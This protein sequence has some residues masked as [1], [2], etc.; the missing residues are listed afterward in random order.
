MDVA[1]TAVGRAIIAAQTLETAL[2]PI[3]ELHRVHSEPDRL[4]RTGGYLSAGAFKVPVSSMVKLLAERGSI[5]PNLENRLSAYVE[6]RH[7]LVHRWI[8]V[9]GIPE[10]KADFIALAKHALRVAQ[11]AHDL[12]QIFVRYVL[13]YAEPEWA[14]ANLEEYKARMARLFQEAHV[15]DDIH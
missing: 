11:E 2:V 6:D 9:H 4:S 14:A 7:L 12:T 3:L 5:A 15:D 13:K 8:Q 10:S 1:Y